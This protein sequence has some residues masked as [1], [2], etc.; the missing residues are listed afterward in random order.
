MVDCWPVFRSFIVIALDAD[1]LVMVFAGFSVK[2]IARL[3][4][5]PDA[6]R[7]GPE[8]MQAVAPTMEA[9]G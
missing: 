9:M 7:S 4:P 6:N 2:M 1:S 8:V 5:T 3:G